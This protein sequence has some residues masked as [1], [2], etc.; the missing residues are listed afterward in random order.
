MISEPVTSYTDFGWSELTFWVNYV[1]FGFQVAPKLIELES[2]C[3][4][5]PTSQTRLPKANSNAG[6]SLQQTIRTTENA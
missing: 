4:S 1:C 2:K 6:S 3:S 5:W